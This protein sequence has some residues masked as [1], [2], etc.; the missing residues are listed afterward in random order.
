LRI[1][2][3]KRATMTKAF[4]ILRCAAFAGALLAANTSAV[5][6]PQKPAQQS[7]A[8]LPTP[9]EVFDSIGRWFRESF[10]SAEQRM[11]RAREEADNFNREAGIAARTTAKAARDAAESVT[12]SRVVTGHQT[13][14]PA[15]NGAPDCVV[16][17]T[18]LCRKHGFETGKSVDMTAAE[19]CPTEVMLNRRQALPGECKPVTFVTRAFCQ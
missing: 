18:A 17:A 5:A 12:R 13:C 3:R 16:A 19:E 14:P 1:D 8:A 6:Q 2:G 11:R 4:P 10:E 9:A 15:A 7:D